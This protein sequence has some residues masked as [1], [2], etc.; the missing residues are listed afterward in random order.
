MAGTAPWARARVRTVALA[1]CRAP[2]Y[3]AHVSTYVRAFRCL[4]VWSVC[5]S[6]LCCEIVSLYRVSSRAKSVVLMSIEAC[7]VYGAVIKACLS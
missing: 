7:P 3:R 1:L 4:S 5:L 2:C 6:V